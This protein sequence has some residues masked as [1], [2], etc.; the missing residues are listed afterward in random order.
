MIDF[1]AENLESPVRIEFF[2]DTIESIR[3]FDLNSQRSV[4]ELIL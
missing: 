1:F 2:G 4:R 3:E